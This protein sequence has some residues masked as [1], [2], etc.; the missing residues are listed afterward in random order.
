MKII[1]MGI[2]ARHR[3]NVQEDIRRKFGNGTEVFAKSVKKRTNPV[4]VKI[5]HRPDEVL[6]EARITETVDAIL[7][8]NNYT[9]CRV[10]YREERAPAKPAENSTGLAWN[11]D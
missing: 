7:M 3:G 10:K 9:F 5:I 8:R 4:Q 1:L 6:N 11:W 2:G